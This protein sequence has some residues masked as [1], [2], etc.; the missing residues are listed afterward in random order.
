[1]IRNC[2]AVYGFHWNAKRVRFSTRMRKWPIK[3][4]S[5]CV[6]RMGIKYS[7]KV[8]IAIAWKSSEYKMFIFFKRTER[9]RSEHLADSSH[10]PCNYFDRLVSAWASY[11][12]RLCKFL[13]TLSRSCKR[14]DLPWK[15]WKIW[16]ISPYHSLCYGWTR[17]LARTVLADVISRSW[18]Q[19]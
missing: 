14:L 7:F 11:Q 19:M 15:L 2:C 8:F 18:R 16:M 12:R 6:Y 1:M 10:L 3:K 4:C 13:F 9:K 17:D 5:L